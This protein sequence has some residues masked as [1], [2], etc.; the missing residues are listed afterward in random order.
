MYE[1]LT[2]KYRPQTFDDICG[3][4]HLVLTLQN[5][6]KENRL[7]NAYIFAGPR[8][9]GKTTSARILAKILNCHSRKE[10]TPC[11][12]CESCRFIQSG[13]DQDVIELDAASNR[14]VEDIRNLREHA[15]YVPLRGKFKIFILDE[16]HMLTKESFNTLLKILEEPPPHV[17]FIFATTEL[18]KIPE[19]ISS[20]CQVFEL[21]NINNDEIYSYLSNIC[22]KEKFEVSEKIIKKIVQLSYGSLRDSISLLE[23]LMTYAKEPSINDLNELVGLT[24]EENIYDLLMFICESKTEDILLKLKTIYSTGTDMMIFTTEVSNI[25]NDMLTFKLCKEKYGAQLDN[26]IKS[27]SDKFT[28][29]HILYCIQLLIN[30]RRYLRENIDPAVITNSYFVKMSLFSNTINVLN[31]LKS[32]TSGNVSENQSDL[33]IQNAPIAKT[34]NEQTRTEE[35]SSYKSSASTYDSQWNNFLLHV[36]TNINPLIKSVLNVSKPQGIQGNNFIIVVPANFNNKLYSD[37]LQKEYKSQIEN[38]LEQIYRQK[39]Q[40]IIEFEEKSISHITEV[41]AVKKQVDPKVADIFQKKFPGS[42]IER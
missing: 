2:L 25:L 4:K 8:G 27:L 6:I 18:N 11:L 15:F 19:T 1:V 23:Q 35:S 29:E 40:L 10:T 31:E 41:A 12:K 14:N 26:K 30:I 20:R 37:K 17:K 39:L 36:Q 16:A 5:A 21:K 33:N 42:T 28:V 34:Y 32:I 38:A 22:E 9:T 24:K 3:Q 7:A 13:S